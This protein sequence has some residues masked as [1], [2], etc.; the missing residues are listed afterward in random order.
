MFVTGKHFNGALNGDK[1]VGNCFKVLYGEERS[2]GVIEKILERKRQNLVGF[3]GCSFNKQKVFF[4]LDSRL[5][6]LFHLENIASL[7]FNQVVETQIVEF[8]KGV[9]QLKL[10]RV[11]GDINLVGVDIDAVLAHHRITREFP[12]E[13]EEQAAKFGS[14]VK[15][16]SFKGRKDLRKKIIFTV[17]GEQTK[18]FDDA[19]SVEEGS[20]PGNFILGVH[21]AD[22]AHYVKENSPLDQEAR[23]RSTSIYF[24]DQVI[25][26]IPTLLSDGLCSLV[27]NQDRL[28]LTM[29]TEIN[30]NG[31][32]V[33]VRVY[34]SVINSC[35]RL[36]YKQVDSFL[37]GKRNSTAEL[38]NSL[39]LAAKLSK[40][41]RKKKLQEGY[42]DLEIQESVLI[43]DKNQE[44]KSIRNKIRGESELIIE[45]F[46]VRANENV[47]EILVKKLQKAVFRIHPTP[48]IEK[49][50][51]LQNLLHYLGIDFAIPLPYTSR[52]FAE[53]VEQIKAAG[54]L[55]E[56]T[57]NALLRSLERATYSAEN[58]G[59]FGLASANY[60]HFTS[61]LRRYPDLYVHRLL[62]ELVF[63]TTEFE[64]RKGEL[65]AE[66]EEIAQHATTQEH[67]AV[68]VERD[69]SN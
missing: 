6:G 12:K 13:V 33:W 47:A 44:V 53:S 16:S 32:S 57:K 9:I 37:K 69:I 39:N 38:A 21:V 14:F 15:E 11:L 60:L 41:L 46:M 36:T 43:V 3:I 22:V 48:S 64:Q 18:D 17:D 54:K 10:L 68:E 29:E 20:K 67:L 24:L 5:K 28:T 45:D 51:Y 4:P 59:H 27:P 34:P 52:E 30:N 8:E 56:F 40:I 25:P 61:P 63:K 58:S 66:V 19:I 1:V 65:L 62:R 42:C 55:F 26:M 2:F 49:I 35:Y 50:T 23:K 7:A 31:E